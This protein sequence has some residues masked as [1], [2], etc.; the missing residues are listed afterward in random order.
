ML[1]RYE[2]KIALLLRKEYDQFKEKKGIKENYFMSF[3]KRKKEIMEKFIGLYSKKET[4]NFDENFMEVYE[5]VSS[6]VRES[7]R[8]IAIS[9]NDDDVEKKRHFLDCDH[10]GL[11]KFYSQKLD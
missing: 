11:I 6:Q 5:N 7:M 2:K 9:K 3:E 1:I 10:E 4:L 8:R